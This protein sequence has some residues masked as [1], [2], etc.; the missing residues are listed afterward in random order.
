MGFILLRLFAAAAV[1]CAAALIKRR[2]VRKAGGFAIAGMVLGLLLF[3]V[4]FLPSLL[5]TDYEGIEPTGEYEVG[6][7]RAILVDKDRAEAFASPLIYGVCGT[8]PGIVMYSRKE[9]SVKAFLIR[10]ALQFVLIEITVLCA[11]FCDPNRA[12]RTDILAGMGICVLVIFVLAHG[13][14]W[15]EDCIAAKRLTEEILAFQRKI[16]WE[17]RG[18]KPVT[19]ATAAMSAATAAASAAAAVTAARAATA[20]RVVDL[21]LAGQNLS[22]ILE[23]KPGGDGSQYFTCAGF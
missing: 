15:I 1:L 4:S 8:L 17:G 7:A 23:V 14:E 6:Q 22:G 19:A 16:E 5:F 11:A 13:I 12:L 18:L 20:G 3:A 10:K 21:G 9:L 2:R